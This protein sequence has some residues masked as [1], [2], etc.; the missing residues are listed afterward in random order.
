MYS[1]ISEAPDPYPLLEASIDSLLVSE[2]TVPRLT[3][4]NEHLQKS[5]SSLT[6]DLEAVEQQLEQERSARK[7]LEES[8]QTKSKDIE[9][10]WQA[11]LEEKKDNWEAKEKSLEDKL[12][13]Q[14]RLLA[15]IKASY[16]VAQRLGHG[17]DGDRESHQASASAAELEIVSSELERASHRLAE[18]EARNEQ[19][20]M[21]LAQI[22]SNTSRQLPQEEDPTVARLRSE[23]STLLRKLEAVKFEKESELH[24]LEGRIR[25]LERE[26]QTLQQDRE[27]LK[28]RLQQW[29]DYPD[30][31][32]ELDVFKVSSQL[33]PRLQ[34]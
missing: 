9:V 33:V 11:V 1:T 28:E 6:Q 4:E 7:Q 25:S 29:R 19:L 23:N 24:K 17:S 18:V 16:E 30:L 31:K 14:E 32:R 5:V 22:S 15:E 3:L 26:A 12:E 20:R 13:N 10:S 2:E 27:E 8:L 34:A 21:E